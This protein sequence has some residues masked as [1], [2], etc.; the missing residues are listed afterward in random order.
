MVAG[1]LGA[2]C[3]HHGCRVAWRR[4]LASPLVSHRERHTCSPVWANSSAVPRPA[5]GHDPW[6]QLLV[7]IQHGFQR[8]IRECKE[9]RCP[10]MLAR[11]GATPHGIALGV[12]NAQGPPRGPTRCDCIHHGH[13]ATTSTLS[14]S[15]LTHVLFL[16][17]TPG[18]GPG[19]EQVHVHTCGSPHRA[20][21]GWGP[22]KSGTDGGC[23]RWC[24]ATS[25]LRATCAARP[26]QSCTQE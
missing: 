11:T 20:A 23:A 7:L 15:F 2:G 1:L 18:H 13:G 4:V 19:A 5:A 14:F 26:P 12:N 9:E 22:C 21:G 3:L 25:S 8:L 6:V 16:A 10:C 17:P 24:S